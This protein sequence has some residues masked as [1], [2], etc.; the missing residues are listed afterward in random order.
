MNTQPAYVERD[1]DIFKVLEIYNTDDPT[2]RGAIL[3]NQTFPLR[4][5]IAMLQAALANATGDHGAFVN[6]S[7]ELQA[8]MLTKQRQ[9]NDG[10][11]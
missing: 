8:L 9:L 2:K 5:K 6:A 10:L 3:V 1:G 7:A 4:R 11:F